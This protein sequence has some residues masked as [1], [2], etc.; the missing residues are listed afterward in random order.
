[1]ENLSHHSWEKRFY[2]ILHLPW[3]HNCHGLKKCSNDFVRTKIVQKEIGIFELIWKKMF[4]KWSPGWH[5]NTEPFSKLLP[6]HEENPSITAGLSSQ[7]NNDAKLWYRHLCK[8]NTLLNKGSYSHIL[9]M[10]SQQCLNFLAD[11]RMIRILYIIGESH[12]I[13]H[14]NFASRIYIVISYSIHNILLSNTITEFFILTPNLFDNWNA[15]YDT[16]MHEFFIYI[17]I[18]IMPRFFHW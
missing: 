4:E 8:L 16:K 3:Q 10:S 5:H 14:W 18:Q 1:M 2:P 7:R 11:I 9:I 15:Q 17:L 6:L 12:F 13:A